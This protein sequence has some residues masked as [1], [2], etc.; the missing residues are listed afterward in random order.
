MYTHTKVGSVR[1]RAELY[2][3]RVFK[4]NCF[5]A[6][7]GGTGKSAATYGLKVDEENLTERKTLRLPPI[8][9]RGGEIPSLKVHFHFCA[10]LVRLQVYRTRGAAGM[11]RKSRILFPTLQMRLRRRKNTSRGKGESSV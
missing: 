2:A 9:R 1:L 10:Y 4:S 11:E 7:V 6:T 5:E 3:L 8:F